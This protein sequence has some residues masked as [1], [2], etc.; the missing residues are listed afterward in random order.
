MENRQPILQVTNLCQHFRF[1]DK[2]IKAVDNVSFEIFEGQTLG[3]V[4]ESGCGKSSI[5][6]SILRLI[7]PTSG[8]IVFNGTDITR[9][10][11]KQLI[12]YRKNMQIIFQ[13]SFASLNPRM[14][15]EEIIIEPLMIFQKDLSKEERKEKVKTLIQQVGL[16]PHQTSY[17]PHELSG[18]QRQRVCIA[19]ALAL[20]PKFIVC[21]ES[22]A[23]LDVSIQAQIVQLLKELQ[24]E[25]RLTYLFISHDLSMVKYLCDKIAV[26]YLG[27]IVETGPTD[28]ICKSPKHPYTKALLASVPI[29][30]PDISIRPLVI[31]EEMRSIDTP[32]CNFNNRCELATPL[33]RRKKPCLKL[34]APGHFVSCFKTNEV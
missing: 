26:M 13:D 1:S 16:L 31:K 29:P 34:E 7:E 15:V 27:Q 4:G 24:Q 20:H 25:F 3:L 28:L 2:T 8:Q 30:D 22:I 6:K 12:P 19:K 21:D 10:K 17:F 9:L 5:A 33:C 14:T 11:Q 23:A 18:G 32:G